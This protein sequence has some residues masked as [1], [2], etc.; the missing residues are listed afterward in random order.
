MAKLTE[1]CATARRQVARNHRVEA[2]LIKTKK[3]KLVGFSPCFAA[4]TAKE[5]FHTAQ[6]KLW[7]AAAAKAEAAGLVRI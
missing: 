4:L 2:N 6:A 3:D 1:M 5:A 7:E